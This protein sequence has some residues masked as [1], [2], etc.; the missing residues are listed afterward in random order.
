M[1][2]CVCAQQMTMLTPLSFLEKTVACV[3]NRGCLL[4]RGCNKEML[5]SSAGCVGSIGMKLITL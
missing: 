1:N 3:T 2:E 4:G 5:L